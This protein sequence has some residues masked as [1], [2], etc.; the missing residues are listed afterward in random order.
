MRFV[1]RPTASVNAPSLGKF[2]RTDEP[3][4]QLLDEVIGQ[5]VLSLIMARNLLEHFGFPT[6]ILQHLRGCLN[7]IPRDTTNKLPV[8]STRSYMK[9]RNRRY[10]DLVPWNFENC[11]LLNNPCTACPNSWKKVTA[12]AT[13]KNDRKINA[14]NYRGKEWFHTVV[15]HQRWTFGSRFG[16]IGDH[17]YRWVVPSPVRFEV[18]RD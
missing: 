1:S 8:I 11:V 15:R 16:Q 10:T 14:G 6:P 9:E 18:S 4:D 2:V 12:S 7:K 13:L 5:R 17:G 3:L